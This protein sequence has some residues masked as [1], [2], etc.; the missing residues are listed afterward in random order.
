MNISFVL[1]SLAS[2]LLSVPSGGFRV[3]YE[4]ASRLAG[5]GHDVV[6]YHSELF[7]G[8]EYPKESVLEIVDY[9]NRIGLPR[10]VLPT[11]FTFTNNVKSFVIP[12]VSDKYIRDGDVVVATAWFSAY[13]VK[14]L[15][16]CKG[17]K[18]YLIQGYEVVGAG[19]NVEI[20]ESTYHLGLRMIVISLWLKQ[21]VE[22][23]GVLVTA[24][25]P[26]GINF[27][28]FKVT[29]PIRARNPY[30]VAMAYH[31]YSIK[32]SKDGINALNLVKKMYSNL[33][34]TLFSVDDKPQDLP[35][36]MDFKHNVPQSDLHQIYNANAIFISSSWQEGFGLPGAEALACGC[37]LATTD[38][39]GV[40]NYAIHGKTALIS[41]PQDPLAL[42]KN[43][44]AF[45]QNNDERMKMAERG[46]RYIQNLSWDK[47]VQEIEKVFSVKP[48]K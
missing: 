39:G 29:T 48:E 25:I 37:A 15:D 5:L 4:Y 35:D 42:A 21:I 26:N 19:S 8:V 3:I 27:D 20:V 1:P 40:R 18:F 6:L 28:V 14:L 13:S 10:V 9:C 47:A 2:S 22:G 12:E 16:K 46:H 23:L 43:I 41:S 33:L 36:W 45:I 38:S 44:I 30:T 31:P 24:Y 11:W 34:V 17:T 7:P 32:G